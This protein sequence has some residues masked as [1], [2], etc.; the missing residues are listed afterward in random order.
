[1]D[2]ESTA[3]PGRARDALSDG[4]GGGGSEALLGEGGAGR[5]PRAAGGAGRE[6]AE[7]ELARGSAEEK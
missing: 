5:A 1:M 6:A 3:L 4:G 7:G 2:I